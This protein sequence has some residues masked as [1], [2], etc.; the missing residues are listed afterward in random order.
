MPTGQVKRCGAA[1]REKPRSV[2]AA[3]AVVYAAASPPGLGYGCRMNPTTPGVTGHGQRAGNADDARLKARNHLT[4]R[5]IG[6][7]YPG[8]RSGCPLPL[9]A[10]PAK[11]LWD[12]FVNNSPSL[13]LKHGIYNT[14]DHNWEGGGK[15]TIGAPANNI[16][17]QHCHKV[18]SPPFGSFLEPDSN[19]RR[20][21]PKTEFRTGGTILRN[22]QPRRVS[23]QTMKPAQA[24]QDV[25]RSAKTSLQL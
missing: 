20:P 22:I 5:G 25:P 17:Q 19:E 24:T 3:A 4:H 11:L 6:K 14:S 15:G 21:L 12:T 8:Y 7:I 9:K 2:L 23:R 1:V 13:I 18:G 16:L 10:S